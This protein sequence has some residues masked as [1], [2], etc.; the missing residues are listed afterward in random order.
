MNGDSLIKHEYSSIKICVSGTA[1]MSFLDQNA[2]EIAKELG[3]EIAR[4]GCI[5]VTGATTGFPFF[6]AIGA[7][8]EGGLSVG[9]SPAASEKEHLDLYNLPVDYMDMITYTGFGY[10]GRDMLL[11]RS[12]DGVICGPGRIGTIHEFTIAYE[13]RRPLAVLEG[14]WKTDENLRNIMKDSHRPN[15]RVIFGDNPKKLVSEMIALIKKCK[16][17]DIDLKKMNL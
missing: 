16:A 8:E 3:R 12:S 5:L 2:M 17:Q 4:Q 9:F 13:D 11:T 1:D 7:K 14:V 10:V 6:A 15:D